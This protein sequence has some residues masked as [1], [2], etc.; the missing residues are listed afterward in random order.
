MFLCVVW[1]VRGLGDL[2]KRK[3]VRDALVSAAPSVICLQETKLRDVDTFTAHTFLPPSHAGTYHAVDS[4]GS[5]G[6]MLTAWD[7]NVF[8]LTFFISRRHTLTTVLS[9]TISD[10]CIA[11]TNVYGPSDHRDS[12]VCLDGLRELEPHIFGV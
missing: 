6:G 7:P 10:H 3:V 2:D 12:P 8:S 9:S 4:D 5:H 1:N 11:V